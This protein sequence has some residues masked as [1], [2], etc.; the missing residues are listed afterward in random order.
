M[1][2]VRRNTH[3]YVNC[4]QCLAKCC[5]TIGQKD[6]KTSTRCRK[7]AGTL[8]LYLRATGETTKKNSIC[9][10]WPLGLFHGHLVYFVVVWYSLWAFRIFFPFWYFGPSQIWQP[11][12][13]QGYGGDSF[14]H[15]IEIWSLPKNLP[16][17][18][19]A[20]PPQILS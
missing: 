7:G 16:S 8:F 2:L 12:P 10:L 1:L 3:F 19:R 5:Q 15:P 20:T 4:L 14:P 13:Y 18:R 17:L 11:W 9:I 6:E